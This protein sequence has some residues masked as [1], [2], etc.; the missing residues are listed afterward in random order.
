[1]SKF[2]S[3]SFKDALKG[4]LLDEASAGVGGVR[5]G[6]SKKNQNTMKNTTNR[7]KPVDKSQRTAA[8]KIKAKRFQAALGEE[9]FED[10]DE[11]I[12]TEAEIHNFLEEE[13]G[14]HIA[15]LLDE[16]FDEDEI[17]AIIMEMIEDDD[18]DVEYLDEDEENLDEGSVASGT[19]WNR[20]ARKKAS[21]DNPKSLDK[22]YIGSEN[23]AN[24]RRLRSSHNTDTGWKANQNRPKKRYI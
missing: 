4:V 13:L 3:E 15:L 8:D 9:E 6:L 12:I 10:D 19:T 20:P 1:M 14:P 17:E 22:N 2:V 21:R 18:E 16:G 23:L 11:E 24:K 5:A 7:S